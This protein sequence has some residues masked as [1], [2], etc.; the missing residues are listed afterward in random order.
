MVISQN[1]SV[2]EVVVVV[3][4]VVVVRFFGCVS[5]FNRVRRAL[6]KAPLLPGLVD[7]LCGNMPSSMSWTG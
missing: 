6:E 7:Q 1:D 3:V 2:A 4:V 5:G